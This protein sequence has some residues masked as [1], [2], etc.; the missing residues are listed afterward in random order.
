MDRAKAFIGSF[1]FDPRS[2]LEN[3]EIGVV[4]NSPAVAIKLAESFDRYIDKVAFKVVLVDGKIRWLQYNDN[5]LERTWINEP[6][7]SWWQRTIVN[8]M[9]LLPVESQ[10]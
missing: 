3:T 10:L 1:N 5:K 4:I 6:Q 2:V 8:M 7:T 9:K